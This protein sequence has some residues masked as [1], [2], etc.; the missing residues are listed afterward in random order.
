MTTRLPAASPATPAGQAT[1]Q[2][3]AARRAM[4][5]PPPGF[6]DRLRRLIW[7]MIWG[8]FA[9]F[10]PVPLHG[11]RR[12][13]L[14]LF[15]ARIGPG[16]VI[17]PSARVWAPWNLV[18]ERGSCLAEGVDCYNVALVSVGEGA[19]I[20]QRAYLCSASH[21]PHRIDF[22]LTAGPITIGA[23]SWVAAEAFIGPGVRIGER[24][25]V[26]ARAVVMRDVPGEQIVGGNP[27]KQIRQRGSEPAP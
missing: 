6:G 26:A 20:S 2:E 3:K 21:D 19:V 4:P 8:I 11:W 5:H 1:A 15:G 7:L 24:A 27:A 12:A 9:R 10:T 13:L 18:M 14:R 16:A 17:Y 22:P 23:Q 25:V